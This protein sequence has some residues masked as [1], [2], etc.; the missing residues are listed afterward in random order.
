[1]PSSTFLS[2]LIENIYTL[3]NRRCL[4]ATNSWQS[5]ISNFLIFEHSHEV[6]LKFASKRAA[7][8]SNYWKLHTWIDAIILPIT[9]KAITKLCC[10][11]THT[12]LYT[13]TQYQTHTQ[14]K[15][16]HILI[17][18]AKNIFNFNRL[19]SCCCCFIFIS[20]YQEKAKRVKIVRQKGQMQ[21]ENAEKRPKEE[22]Q[23]QQQLG[24]K[25]FTLLPGSNKDTYS[26][27]ICI[28]MCAVNGYVC[29]CVCILIQR[30]NSS[31]NGNTSRRPVQG[32][33]IKNGNWYAGAG[34]ESGLC[35]AERGE[36]HG[37]A[38]WESGVC[39]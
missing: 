28:C 30:P 26:T 4:C 10:T 24:N 2:M 8:K 31:H 19:T 32:N 12:C 9:L 37:R 1:M 29:V 39:S 17:A 11:H 7:L 27:Y 16:L 13:H 35:W 15:P 22:Q 38:D 20:I 14:L 18:S 21:M 5:P 6:F 36:G 23:Q 33:P 34:K 25:P 3:W